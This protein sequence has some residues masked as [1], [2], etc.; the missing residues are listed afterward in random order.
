[1]ITRDK[2]ST[3]AVVTAV[4]DNAASV[5]LLAANP[6]RLGATIWNDSSIAVY[7]KLGTTAS[8]TSYTVKLASGAYYEVPFG[9][10]GKI[11]GIWVSDPGDGACR[12]TEL[13]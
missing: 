8:A 7:V 9:Y 4:A 5:E 2:R 6:Y 3:T 13:T 11:D 1:M 12:I 10:T